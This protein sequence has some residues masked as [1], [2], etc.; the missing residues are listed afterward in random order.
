MNEEPIM[1]DFDACADYVS[2]STGVNR[3]IVISVLIAETAYM[4]EIGIISDVEE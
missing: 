2:N 3:D 1:M 4:K